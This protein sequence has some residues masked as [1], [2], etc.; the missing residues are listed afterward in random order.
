MQPLVLG[1][2]ER[3]LPWLAV[4][5]SDERVVEEELQSIELQ[6]RG[7]FDL[8]ARVDR[9]SRP[10]RRARAR[11]DQADREAIVAG[12]HPVLIAEQFVSLAVER[13]RGNAMRAGRGAEV[14]LD[15]PRRRVF[16]AD[17]PAVE[18]EGDRR[19]IRA[20]DFRFEP[21][22][23]AENRAG[24]CQM[25][26]G[27]G[28]GRLGRRQPRN[29]EVLL[30]TKEAARSWFL[31]PQ[32]EGVVAGAQQ[33]DEGERNRARLSR[34]PILHPKA[35]EEAIVGHHFAVEHEVPIGQVR[36]ALDGDRSLHESPTL[37]SIADAKGERRRQEPSSRLQIG[38]PAPERR[39]P[40]RVRRRLAVAS[41]GEELQIMSI[42]PVLT[43]EPEGFA[44]GDLI[45]DAERVGFA[46]PVQLVFVAGL[47]NPEI[48]GAAIGTIEEERERRAL[49]VAAPRIEPELD[50]ASRRRQ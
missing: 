12:V 48:G 36:F 29:L 22:P 1:Q 44:Q 19:D 24:Y 35:L 3:Q 40:L 33:A 46:G 13:G 30:G 15:A 38:R 9:H 8:G 47:P 28:L 34:R 49:G 18:Q 31:D 10:R 5:R 6:S 4:K 11:F 43:L 21:D 25:Y 7:D 17:P 27:H 26:R 42:G 2:R 50:C 20:L 45:V 37:P 39:H 23:A 32:D 16:E 14:E 41:L